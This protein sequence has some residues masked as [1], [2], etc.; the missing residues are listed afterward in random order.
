[1]LLFKRL[2]DLAHQNG[3]Q[4]WTSL[5]VRTHPIFLEILIS[6]YGFQP[7]PKFDRG[8]SRNGPLAC[9]SRN[10]QNFPGLFQVHNFIRI[11]KTKIVSRHEILQKF[12]P[13]ESQNHSK[14]PAFKNK[15]IVFLKVAFRTRKV[16]A[17]FDKRA[18]GP[19]WSERLPLSLKP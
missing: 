6:K 16:F 7:V 3:P 15:W 9:V 13:F 5:E 12:S 2:V 14:K 11:V 19:N 1:M 10:P 17:T 8:L 18:P 4:R